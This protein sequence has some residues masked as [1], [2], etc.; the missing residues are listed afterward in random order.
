MHKNRSLFLKIIGLELKFNFLP[1]SIP[2]R[3]NTLTGMI[4]DKNI[5]LEARILL[6]KNEYKWIYNEIYTYNFSCFNT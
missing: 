1:I 4:D 6:L 3:Q 5:D 2:M